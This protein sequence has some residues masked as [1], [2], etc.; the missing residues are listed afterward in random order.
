MA[1]ET[2]KQ[3]CAVGQRTDDG[4]ACDTAA[5]AFR[6]C[7]VHR[8]HN[9]RFSEFFCNAGSND[10]QHARVPA[11]SPDDDHPFQL[12]ARLPVQLFHR[13]LQHQLLLF[14]VL[15][16]ALPNELAGLVG[17]KALDTEERALGKQPAAR[18]GL[19]KYHQRL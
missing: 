19:S 8:K 1:A 17:K 10:P 2:G 15:R 18:F 11:F 5:G 14:C 7:S 9:A 13:L 4:K 12:A 3:R 6:L 16:H